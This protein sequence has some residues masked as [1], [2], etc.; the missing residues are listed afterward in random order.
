MI[1]FG[2]FGD[3]L[4]DV[5]SGLGGMTG[6][7]GGM[8]SAQ[9]LSAA[10]QA[11]VPSQGMFGAFH[12][13]LST[14]DASGLTGADKLNVLGA[15]LKDMAPG[16]RG[17]NLAMTQDTIARRAGGG[18][19]GRGAVASSNFGGFPPYRPTPAGPPTGYGFPLDAPGGLSRTWPTQPASAI[20]FGPSPVGITR[21]AIPLFSGTG[22]Q[23][24]F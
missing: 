19:G 17:G 7:S 14:A 13:W 1:D 16:S 6:A 3:V 9:P 15:G 5:G 4:G 22:G 12:N 11:S 23:A 2:S 21:Y 20:G 8:G 24:G 18:R 10:P